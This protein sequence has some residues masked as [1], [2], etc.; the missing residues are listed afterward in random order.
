MIKNRHS[1]CFVLLTICFQIHGIVAAQYHE[2]RNFVSGNIPVEN[3]NWGIA[4]HPETG[5]IY[6]ANS[7][8]LVEYDGLTSNIYK[9]PFNKGVRSVCIDPEGKIFT[10]S[11]EEFGFW[12][13]DKNCR[14]N[15]NSLK[16][17]T[18]PNKNDEI[19]KI[20]YQD[21]K[22]Y[23]QSFTSIYVYDY[24]VVKQYKAEFT[25][26]FMFPK[27]KGF[28]VQ[29][30]D[31]GLYTFENGKYVFIPGSDIF[32]EF[33]IHTIVPYLK[34]SYLIGT[35][36]NGLFILNESK[37]EP[38]PCEVSEFLR[39]NTCNAG[40]AINDSLFVFGTILNGVVEFNAKGKIKQ[41]FS[42]ANGLKNNTV[43]SL[44]TDKNNGVWVGLDQGT[45]YLEILSPIV[46]YTNVTGTLGTIYT[47][48][49]KNNILF[50]GTNQGLFKAHLDKQEDY[51]SFSGVGIV[52][53]SQGQV[54]TLREYDD[55]I[56][57]GHNDGTYIATENSFRQISAITG[58]WTIKPLKDFLIE[59][60]Y[61]GL[62]LFEKEPGNKWKFRNKIK[63]FNE[64]SRHIETDYLGF[65]W[66]S[67]HQRG[68]YKLELNEKLDSVQNQNFFGE[69]SGSAGNIDVFKINN[70]IIFTGSDKLYTFDYDANKIVP[71]TVLNNQLREFSKTIQIVPF[72]GSQYW[73]VFENKIALF[74]VNRNFGIKKIIEFNQKN[75][76]SPG[77]DLEIVKIDERNII[78]PIHSGFVILDA[79]QAEN[80][81]TSSNI[82][83]KSLVFQ[84]KGN[85]ME[86]CGQPG[87]LKVPYK[88]NNLRVF[89]SDPSRFNAEQKLYYYRIPQLEEQWHTTTIN[90]FSYNNIRFGN[91]TIEIKSDLNGPVASAKFTIKAPWYLTYY[92]FI[93]YAIIFIA[94]NYFAYLI[95]HYELDKQKKMVEM[96]LRRN[97]LENELDIKSNELM[98]TMRY[99]IQKNEILNELKHE[100]D[101]LVEQSSKYPVKHV[102]N[103]E[104]IIKE[105]LETQTESWKNALNNL[106]LSEQGFFRRLKEKHPDLTPN[107]LRLCSYLRMNFTTK[108]IAHLLNIS[109]RGVEIGRYRLRKKMNLPHDVNLS[110]Y[111][112][113]S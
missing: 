31:K 66:A 109:G 60:T 20:Y 17:L 59:G 77:N 11:F 96:E 45:N 15:Y 70:R 61:T 41:V 65:V 81:K 82:T 103:L 27:N 102:R 62:V 25:Q 113:E 28:L 74:D 23:F 39:Y 78:F 44:F 104:K 30:L 26:L 38:F 76:H 91:Y 1:V 86:L 12:T 8:G 3:Q 16:L 34:N 51:Y 9:L 47:I 49:K 80:I 87:L 105:G 52:P 72:E 54:W 4:Q 94:L 5:Y 2:I 100:I 89:F 48:L 98:L 99:L 29:V 24:K 19:W 50:I 10:G 107:D 56:I 111:L 112:M 108:E 57:C 35:A 40:V 79:H 85:T 22:V 73:F 101:A 58:G 53:G 110:E 33:K 68:I 84:G 37:I 55:Q 6:F 88:M 14:L 46:Q 36:N 83:V 32:K 75:I 64:P 43:L 63:G 7:D 92:A 42:F 21:G 90:N 106:K 67:H 93:A 18:G 97:K 13:K 69:I 95:F 71:F